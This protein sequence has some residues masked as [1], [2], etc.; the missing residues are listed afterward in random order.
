MLNTFIKNRG[1]TKTII[2]NNNKNNINEIAWDA[3]Y[4]GEEANIS[5]N[6][7]N[8]GKRDNYHLS[9]DNNDLANLLNVHTVDLPLE[10]R[11]KRDFKRGAEPKILQIEL[12]GELEKPHISSPVAN[13][14][15]IV[16]VT[17]DNNSS[18]KY[19]LTP[20]RRHRKPR[21][22]KTYKVYRHKKSS[23]RSNKKTARTKSIPS[24]MFSL[25]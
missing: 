21:T 2:H 10:Q 1:I 22:H 7:I 6:F 19:T 3:D 4:D 9:L 8:N 17:I 5:L 15:F 20:R 11:L 16:P 25:L 23:S 14:E 13:E 12:E 24:K 18:D